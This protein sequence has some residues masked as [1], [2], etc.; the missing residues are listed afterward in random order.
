MYVFDSYGVV[1]LILVKKII[2]VQIMWFW[3][4]KFSLLFSYLL[5]SFIKNEE[6]KV[7]R[8]NNFLNYSHF[9]ILNYLSSVIKAVN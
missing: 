9:N 5:Y 1:N 4:E 7:S 6:N 8:K 3:L 2:P